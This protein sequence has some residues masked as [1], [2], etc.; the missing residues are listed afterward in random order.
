LDETMF[1][2]APAEL[3]L[4]AHIS[5][6]LA[7]VH[8]SASDAAPATLEHEALH[9]ASP[10]EKGHLWLAV[11]QSFWWQE[12]LEPT[13][14]ALE[15]AAGALAEAPPG[16]SARVVLPALQAAVLCQIGPLEQAD[17]LLW[18]ARTAAGAEPRPQ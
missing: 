2:K 18:Q 4:R 13:R 11:A 8:G 16:R 5:R 14:L 15:R 9:T 7:R 3:V 10:R 17:R 6:A 1:R 12:Q